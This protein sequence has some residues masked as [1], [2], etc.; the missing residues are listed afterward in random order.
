M[1]NLFRAPVRSHVD[2]TT[3]MVNARRMHSATIRTGWGGLRLLPAVMCLIL[4][5]AAALILSAAAP[6]ASWAQVATTAGESAQE[7]AD[8]AQASAPAQASSSDPWAGVEEM[9]VTSSGTLEA[10][11]KTSVS[12]TAFDSSELEAIGVSDVSD[13]A[14]YTPNL[15]IRT[16]GATAATFFIR[17]VGLNDLTANA[18]GSV[19][20]YVDDAPKNLPAIQLGQ[21]YDVE[22]VTILKGPQGSGAGRNASAGAIKV[23]TK[24]PTG[25]FGGFLRTD[26]GNYDFLNLEGALEVP[27]IPDVLAT[28]MAFSVERRDGVVTNRCGE[29]TA[30]DIAAPGNACGALDEDKISPGLQKDMNNK[31]VWAA[32][33]TNSY[34]PPVEGMTWLLTFQGGR[35]DQLGTVGE[36]LGAQNALGTPDTIG[37]QQ[38]EIAAEQAQ[39]F[40]Q[41]DIPNRAECRRRFPG[42]RMAQDACVAQSSLNR[43]S[44]TQRFSEILADRPLDRK[45][46]EGAYNTPG[47]ERQTNWGALLTGEWDLEFAR[48]KSITGFER[49]DRERLLD[50]DYSPSVIFEF[51]IED[52]AW[53]ANQDLQ[54]AGELQ[55]IPLTWDTGVFFLAEELDYDQDTLARDGPVEP[56]FQGYIQKTKSLGVYAQFEVDLLQDFTLEAGARYNWEQ[57]FFDAEILLNPDRP[58][59]TDQCRVQLSGAVPP[60][61]RTITVDHPTGTVGLSYRVDDLRSV[62]FKYSHGWKGAQFNV[63]DGRQASEVTDVADPEVIDAFE[64][65]FEGSWWDERITLSGALFWYNYQNYQVFTFTND[66]NVPPSRVVI[67][68]DDA[69]LYGAELEG[70]IE[71]VTG[72]RGSFRFGWLESRFLDFTDSV[73]RRTESAGNTRIVTDFNGN[74]L[75]NAPKFKVS[76]SLEYEFDLGKSGTLT[77]NWSFTWSDDV[78]FDPSGGRGSP[79][80][81]GEI[82]LPE[83]TIGQEAF[84]LQN[85][86]VTYVPET[87]N[88]E[89]AVWVRNLTN[90]VYKSLAF[91]ASAGPA[92]VGNLL[93]LPRTYGVSAKVTF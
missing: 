45:P 71:P 52:D 35:L 41:F 33:I 88:V 38:P 69:Q 39:V 47:Y 8:T 1:P 73:I 29:L 51:E 65:G 50:F 15:E 43:Q 23:Y 49:Y 28:R 82:F 64:F 58:I 20:V 21:I 53:Q 89:M 6:S 57:K 60:C 27:I 75:P 93:G 72:L 59:P 36:H 63:R 40:S 31:D 54:L 19:A 56:R 79:D 34:T 77:P 55:S 7:E 62:Y 68:A 3:R 22:G 67:N 13:V 81:N 74:P 26:Y 42:D 25:E 61:Q 76:G 17:G 87:G 78:A 48:L 80:V 37:Y 84:L 44:A 91:D 66:A 32:R 18:S 86:R 12:V 11:T 10:L 9:V 30:A 46:F 5:S 83:N 14:A 70:S 24:K 90:E 4:V 85:V 16:A 2:A 92:I